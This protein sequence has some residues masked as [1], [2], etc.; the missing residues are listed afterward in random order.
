VATLKPALRW[1][2]VIFAFAALL[3]LVT[4]TDSI[5]AR[6]GL[7]AG[8]RFGVVLFAGV[9]SGVLTAVYSGARGGMH[10]LIGAVLSA[11][12]LSYLIFGGA[13]Q[14]TVYIAAASILAGALTEI[15]LR[16]RAGA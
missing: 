2:G 12:I 3:L 14:S 9:L 7:G 16:Q 6:V 10:S 13:W 8:A 1:T 4:V 11:P 15:V 5:A